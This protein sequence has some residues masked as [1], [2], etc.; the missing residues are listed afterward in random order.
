MYEGEAVWANNAVG[1]AMRYE[2]EDLLR[3]YKVDLFLSGHYHAY[4]RSC[5]G[6]FRS[7]CHNGGPTHITVGSAG[8]ML[9]DNPL[10]RNT[11]SAKFIK[12]EYGYGRITVMNSTALHFEFVKAGDQNDTSAGDVHDDVWIRR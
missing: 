4:H 3:D 6:L 12:Q 2:M 5:A 1:I 9:D 11:W 7:K 10:F 8:A